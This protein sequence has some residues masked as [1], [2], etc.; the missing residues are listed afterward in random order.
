MASIKVDD[1][2]L[3]PFVYLHPVNFSLMLVPA[4]CAKLAR[5]TAHNYFN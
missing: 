5:C 1:S 4:F 3:I 2:K